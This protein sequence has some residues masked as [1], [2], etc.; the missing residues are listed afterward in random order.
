M[1]PAPLESPP[2]TLPP[3]DLPERRG[4]PA[5]R[6]ATTL[7]IAWLGDELW[8]ASLEGASILDTWR[9]PGRVRTLDDFEASLGAVLRG[10]DFHGSE[11]LLLLEND[12][13]AHQVEFVPPGSGSAAQAYL[14]GRLLRHEKEFGEQVWCAQRT[15]SARSDASFLLHM[16][17]V[18][19][20][21]RLNRI[22]TSRGLVLSRI[23]PLVV[24]LL[25]E[26]DSMSCA[27]GEPALVAAEACGTTTLLVGKPGG[28]LVF[29][30]TIRASWADE[31]ARIAVETNRSLLYAKQQLGTV[32]GKV[33]L[34][35]SEEGAAAVR[36]R[37]GDQREIVSGARRVYDWIAAAASIPAADPR[38][39]VAGILRSRRR[40]KLVRS[41]LIAACWLFLASVAVTTWADRAVA[42][43]ERQD[44]VA[45]RSRE[46]A[47]RA[48][49]GQ[50]E[51]RSQ[52]IARNGELVRQSG[53]SRL[54]PVPAR[55]L[56][57]IAGLLPKEMRLSEFRV[58]RD[59]LTAT[60]S[61][62][63]YGT[64]ESDEETA[65]AE[66]GALGQQLEQGPLH[67][68]ITIPGRNLTVVQAA[69]G[70]STL[71]GFEFGGTLLED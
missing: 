71:L 48:E 36:A 54:P 60:W 33:R 38:N 18:A 17:P 52:E 2:A 56:A 46:A 28:Q 68:H 22:I 14:E 34:F 51:R 21:D 29:S 15:V 49:L 12:L 69:A 53:G 44:F 11:V 39:L 63:I 58:E 16:L 8:A 13:F 23:H 35:G 37:C 27:A 70:G 7:G 59:P 40:A 62:R 66:L 10:L 50:L 32:V 20:L 41:G 43:S 30:R 55:A 5:A 1:N 64:I 45:V 9:T 4:A 24:P 26:I 61:F 25:L 19:F 6:T 57:A 67:A 31:P 3:P 42:N 65:Q 47:L